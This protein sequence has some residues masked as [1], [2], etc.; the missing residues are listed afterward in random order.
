MQTDDPDQQSS[1][2][3]QQEHAKCA[4][5][6]EFWKRREIPAQDFNP[7]SGIQ[8]FRA[9]AKENQYERQRNQ[10]RFFHH[11][12]LYPIQPRPAREVLTPGFE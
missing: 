2:R 12:R 11:A 5:F 3:Q 6:E 4:R 8:Y 9:R 10:N 7:S 1:R